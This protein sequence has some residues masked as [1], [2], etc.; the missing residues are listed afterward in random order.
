MRD[1][2]GVSDGGFRE[3]IG[4]RN[5]LGSIC[6]PICVLFFFP[7]V[8]LL[9]CPIMVIE[10]RRE[11]GGPL[12]RRPYQQSLTLGTGTFTK[13]GVFVAVVG[14]F[15]PTVDPFSLSKKS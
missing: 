13:F 15:C 12:S 14:G 3:W 1:C 10:A 2:L 5:E 4:C 7:F 9:N 11:S 6:C 8:D